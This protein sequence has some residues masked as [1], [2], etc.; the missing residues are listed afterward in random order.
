MKRLQFEQRKVVHYALLFAIV[1]LQ[2]LAVVTWYN[3]TR[4]AKAFHAMSDTNKILKYTNLMNNSLI[5]SQGHFNDYIANKKE[6]SLTNYATAL[7]NV[8]ALTDSLGSVAKD[9]DEFA[10]LFKE[11]TKTENQLLALRASIDSII[12]A[13][14]S[15]SKNDYPKPFIHQAFASENLLDNI[16]TK[17]Y[18]KVKD[19][20][21]RGF[22]SR[23]G[24]AFSGK[25][26]VK[27]EYINTIL[28]VKYKDKVVAGDV[29]QQ[30][31]NLLKRSDKFYQTEFDKLKKSFSNLRTG[32]QKLMSLNNRL[33]MLSQKIAASYNQYPDLT[34][35]NDIKN[36]YE[37]AR[38]VR[39]YTIVLL[40]LLMFGISIVLF[41]FTR[42]AFDYEKKLADANEMIS[43]SLSFK[44]RITGMISHEIRSPLGIISL[45]SK[46]A[47]LLA[48]DDETKEA[49]R[50]IEFTTSSLLLLSNQIL[51]YSKDETQKMELKCQNFQL[52]PVVSSI[53]ET[54][55][56]LVESKGNKLEST[57]NI[58]AFEVCSDSGKIHQ[59]FYNIVGNANKFT[60]NGL[61]RINADAKKISEFE[62]EFKVAVLDN[63]IG[64][65]QNDLEHIFESYYQGTVSEKVNDLGIGLGLNICK[66]I[67]ELYGGKIAIESTQGKGTVVSFN[68]M[69]A[70]A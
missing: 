23:I 13:R 53:T 24:D 19:A 45:Y 36:Q 7:E 67:V 68:L 6:S 8:R 64:I 4:L 27:K 65:A 41:R 28:T 32:D 35:G 42:M 38:S 51:E 50:S 14:F 58:G 33:L 18:I 3:E 43:R 44:N 10:H 52:K 5:E 16:E 70:L 54:M 21:R 22:F 56:A 49:F 55:S 29:E 11:K 39:N 2:I 66:E 15:V 34:G 47:G 20:D 37:T 25:V 59:L 30:I 1:L 61:I 31:E 60:E 17:S 48:K 26:S 40:I 46:K 63:G 12:N 62:V 69:L 9:N 57:L